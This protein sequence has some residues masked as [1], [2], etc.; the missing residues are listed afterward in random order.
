MLWLWA[1]VRQIKHHV[2]FLLGAA[3]ELALQG[4]QVDNGNMWLELSRQE[5]N[6]AF[7]VF[8]YLFFLKEN[9]YIS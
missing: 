5:G 6:K 7:L 4:H 1:L 8:G 9:K 3:E 2:D